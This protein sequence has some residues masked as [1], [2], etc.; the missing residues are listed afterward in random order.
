MIGI[1][2]V[3]MSENPYSKEYPSSTKHIASDTA[4]KAQFMK[5]CLNWLCNES[6]VHE[7]LLELVGGFNPFE[8]Y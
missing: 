5:S 3:G 6:L 2:Q 7:I 1:P 4:M 8:T